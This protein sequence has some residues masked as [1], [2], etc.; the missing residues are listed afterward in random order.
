MTKLRTETTTASA[1]K[2]LRIE[3]SPTQSI[4]PRNLHLRT[5]RT[6]NPSDGADPSP[7]QRV[8]RVAGRNRP[9]GSARV[10]VAPAVLDGDTHEIFRVIVEV[11]R[12]VLWWN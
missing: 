7:G 5:S 9:A 3:S 6:K 12:D 11:R 10:C 8:G 4:M 2:V 1:D